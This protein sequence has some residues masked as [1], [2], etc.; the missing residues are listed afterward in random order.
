MATVSGAS[1]N[2]AIVFMPMPRAMSTIDFTT[3]WSVT[4]LVRERMKS[5]SI[6][7]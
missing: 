7:R 6:F 3:S 1:T 4:L 5:P 2:S